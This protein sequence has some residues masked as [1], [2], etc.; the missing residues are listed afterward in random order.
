ME[1]LFSTLT[2]KKVW[3]VIMKESLKLSVQCRV[4]GKEANEIVGDVSTKKRNNQISFLYTVLF[5][6]FSNLDL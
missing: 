3:E 5:Y 2:R 1:E 6:P 4:V